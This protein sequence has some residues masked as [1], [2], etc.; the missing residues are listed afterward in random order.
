M[1]QLEDFK[2]YRGKNYQL[3]KSRDFGE[4][5]FGC[6]PGMVKEFARKKQELPARHVIPVRAFVNGRN[7]FDFEFIIYSVLFGRSSRKKII[8]HCTPDQECRFRIILGETLFGPN[9]YH[10]VKAQFR[11]TPAACKFLPKETRLFGEFL[12][13]IASDKTLF[14]IFRDLLK[15]HAGPRTLDQKIREYFENTLIKNKWKTYQNIPGLTRQLARNYIICAQLRQEMEMFALCPENKQFE[16]INQTVEFHHFDERNVAY[17]PGE[18]DKRKKLKVVQARSSFFEL[19]LKNRLIRTIDLRKIEPVRKHSAVKPIEKPFMG[20]TFL[21]VGS[22]FTPKRENSCLVVWTE[23]KGIMVDALMGSSLLAM[24]Y[25]ITESD[26]AYLFL[27]HVH[28]DHD[29]GIIEKL[30]HGKRVRLIS[31]RIVFESFLRKV[32]A[33]TCFSQDVIEGFIDFV[34]VEPHKTIKLPGFKNSYFKFDYS[35]H[36]IPTGRFTLTYKKNGIKKTISHSGDTKYDVQKINQWRQQGILSTKRRDETLGF[37]WDADLIIHDI[38]GGNL[39]TELEA[40]KHV[41]DS[42]IK[43]LILVHQDMAPSANSK[44]R[45]AWEGQT[46]ELIKGSPPANQRELEIFKQAMSFEKLNQ[47]HLL[48]LRAPSEIQHFKDNEVVVYQNE[49]GDSFYIILDGLAEILIDGKPFTI[50]EKGNIFGELAITA[51]NPMRQATV[52]AKGSLTLLKIR[53]K[54]YEKLNRPSARRK[55]P[56]SLTN[57]SLQIFNPSLLASLALGKIIR[58]RKNETLIQHGALDTGLYVILSGQ[59]ATLD[60]NNNRAASSSD[61]N[62]GA[63]RLKNVPSSATTLAQTNEVY[64]IHLRNQDVKK[65]FRLFPSFYGTIHTKIKKRESSAR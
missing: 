33:I 26:V 49:S 6:P 47:N 59:V 20:V 43:K 55:D 53:N 62:L 13:K 45:F 14:G 52:R 44:F 48:E 38:G 51:K 23:G 37:I 11:K 61:G 30:L 19:Y 27:S 41:D 1:A 54:D 34:E 56:Y 64:A 42:L 5:V 10:L 17:I 25:G 32:E 58:W 60:R 18:R 40:L 31:S 8:I 4:I 16:F 15:S 22:G 3:L 63:A 35:L 57:Y 29:V 50:Y 39:H 2:I 46:C 21:G 28:S 7:N 65:M 24:N 9:F 36:S 12:Q